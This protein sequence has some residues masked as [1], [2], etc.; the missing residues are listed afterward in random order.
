[1]VDPPNTT[2][3]KD[4]VESIS[5]GDVSGMSVGFRVVGEYYDDEGIRHI[6]DADLFECSCVTFPAYQATEVSY[7]K[8]TIAPDSANHDS[9]DEDPNCRNKLLLKKIEIL[10]KSND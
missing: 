5:R 10:E 7:R 2:V 8:L 4:I 1:M 6:T 3:G 9:G